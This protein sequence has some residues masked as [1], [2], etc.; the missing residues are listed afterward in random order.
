MHDLNDGE[1]LG[2]RLA[3]KDRAEVFDAA[4]A[5]SV[6]GRLKTE[7]LRLGLTLKEL[8]QQTNLSAAM[9]SKIENAQTAPSLRTVARLSKALGIHVGSFF[10]DFDQEEEPSFTKA[11][12][13]IEVQRAETGGGLRYELLAGTHPARRMIQPFLITVPEPRPQFPVYQHPGSEFIYML[14]GR[15]LFNYGT[16]TY[17]LAAGNSLLFNGVVAHGP[18][19][20]LVAPVK[21]VSVTSERL[22]GMPASDIGH[23][24][25]VTMPQPSDLPAEYSAPGLEVAEPSG[26]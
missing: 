18:G 26:V 24:E 10:S 11:G 6:A 2:E 12:E 19:L 3:E 21:F 25:Y 23:S 15:F 5:A 20:V 7:R 13:G 4:I 22:P 17:E 16:K 9:L 8:A 14:E 1:P